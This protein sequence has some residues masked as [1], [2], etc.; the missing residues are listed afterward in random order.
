[1]APMLGPHVH[2]LVGRGELPQ[3]VAD[4]LGLDIHLGEGLAV[5]DARHLAWDVAIQQVCVFTISGL[6]VGGASWLSLQAH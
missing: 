1:M 2:G 6:S 4:R 5:V 3:V